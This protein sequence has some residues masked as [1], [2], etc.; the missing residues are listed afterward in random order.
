[1]GKTIASAKQSGAEPGSFHRLLTQASDVVIR[2]QGGAPP[3]RQNPIHRFQ[4]PWV[5]IRNG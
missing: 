3:A 1:M 4:T 2:F 5:Y